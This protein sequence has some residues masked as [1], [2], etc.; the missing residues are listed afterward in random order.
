MKQHRRQLRPSLI[1]SVESRRLLAA[2]VSSSTVNG[3]LATDT[4]IDNYTIAVTK[5]TPLVVSLG[6]PGAGGFV[7]RMQIL[8]PGGS[9]VG[10]A[11]AAVG[12][13]AKLEIQASQTGT[14]TVRVFE[15]GQ[16]ASGNYTLT[17]FALGTQIDTDTG[18]VESGRRFAAN[19][20][21][22]DLDVWTFSATKGQQLAAIVTENTSGSVMDLA[23]TL[24]A[25]DGTVISD[26]DDDAG[27]RIDHKAT[28][29]G[30]YYVIV[31]ES[32]EDE[33]GTYGITITR[34]PGPQYAGDPDTTFLESGDS[35]TVSLPGGDA[36]VWTVWAEAGVSIS[37]TLAAVG[38]SALN[39]QLL[40]YGPDGT[41]LNSGSG[42]ASASVSAV[43]PLAGFYW[44]VGRDLEA[45][46]G[47]AANFIYHLSSGTG[48]PP[49]ANRILT[50]TGTPAPDKMVFTTSGGELVVN[51]NGIENR[52]ATADFDV[53]N[54]YSGNGADR[55]DLTAIDINTYVSAGSGDDTV[56][57]GGGRDSLT[58]GG[59]RNRL[60]G[61]AND[62][63]LNGSNGRDFLYG[64][65]GADRLYGNN[66][67]DNLDGG[68]GVD[69]LY[70]G[71]GD[72]VLI[73]GGSNDKLYAGAGN[74]TLYGG[75]GR[76]LMNGD[77][78]NDTFFAR[79]GYIDLINGGAGNDIGDLDDDDDHTSIEV[80]G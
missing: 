52:F 26:I 47:G 34:L 3:I 10:S 30:T 61:G 6:N 75:N 31:S 27:V 21:P 2:L 63:R 8:S 71:D 48:A 42:S 38:N 72:D 35:R 16:D 39:P 28:Q 11:S 60:Y 45:D 13:G 4:E 73:G 22:G 57:G 14:Y 23:V 55:V 5:G 25:P 67:N 64:E 33:S 9:V 29:T 59:G 76:D 43:A 32:G 49:I 68:G 62:D 15:D 41:L 51:V 80:I 56:L 20:S 17:A 54:V 79:D 19:V 53:I 44:I 40:L 65:G 18:V 58:G 46:T 36:D 50:I 24:V 77:A 66:G 70:G 69:R 1:E 74:D 78:G 7:P 12:A 37:S